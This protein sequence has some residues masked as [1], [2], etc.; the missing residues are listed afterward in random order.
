M[1][2]VGVILIRIQ[3]CFD[4]SGAD[5]PVV[6]RQCQNLV[7]A[8]FDHAGFVHTDMAGACGRCKGR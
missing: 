3:E 5:F 2:V 4:L 8:E 1:V 7:S 6:V